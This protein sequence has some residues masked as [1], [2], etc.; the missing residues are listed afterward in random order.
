MECFLGYDLEDC[1]SEM[2]VNLFSD[3]LGLSKYA[4]F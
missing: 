1:E 2:K 3:L 4:N